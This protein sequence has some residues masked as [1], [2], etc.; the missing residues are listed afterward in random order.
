[1]LGTD[2]D[3]KTR[4]VHGFFGGVILNVPVNFTVKLPFHRAVPH[5]S[6]QSFDEAESGSHALNFIFGIIC[7][8][9]WPWIK[10]FE[11]SWLNS[12]SVSR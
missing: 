3:R 4:I 5:A 6:H 8:V 9:L 1:M 2:F 12:L 10:L 11:R 7:I